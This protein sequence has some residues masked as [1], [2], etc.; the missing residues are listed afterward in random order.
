MKTVLFFAI[1]FISFNSYSQLEVVETP[2]TIEIGK[3]GAPLMPYD[4]KCEKTGDTYYFTYKDTKFKQLN[5]YKTFEVVGK[6]D[7]ESLYNIITKNMEA[8]PDEDVMVKLD[9]GFL[10]L[11]YKK[12]FGA[13]YVNITHELYGSGEVFGTVRWLTQKQ[14]DRLFGKR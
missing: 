9:K 12:S 10:F 1:A 7:F 5:E 6:K 11:E 2:E 14:I 3:I 13:E 8:Q 4:I